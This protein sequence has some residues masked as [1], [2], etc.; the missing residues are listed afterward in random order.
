MLFILKNGR[1][2]WHALRRQIKS[3]VVDGN[4]HQLLTRCSITGK[5]STKIV[6][7]TKIS[8]HNVTY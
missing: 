6:T 3:V 5:K 8:M 2:M 4:V 1:N 7:A